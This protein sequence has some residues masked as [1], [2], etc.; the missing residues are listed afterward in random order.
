MLFVNDLVSTI[1]Y[2]RNRLSHFHFT[3]WNPET[4]EWIIIKEPNADEYILL[5]DREIVDWLPSDCE[6]GKIE[7]NLMMEDGDLLKF[8]ERK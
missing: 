1:G 7:I 4:D 6:D 5:C 8:K 2:T 3:I